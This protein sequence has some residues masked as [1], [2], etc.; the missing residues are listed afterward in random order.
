M[1]ALISPKGHLYEMADGGAAGQALR[2]FLTP[3]PPVVKAGVT[4]TDTLPPP[5]PGAGGASITGQTIAQGEI[6]SD[7]AYMGERAWKVK[8]TLSITLDISGGGM[9]IIG[10][11][12]G[13][14]GGAG[15]G[16]ASIQAEGTGDGIYYVSTKGVLLGGSDTMNLEMSISIGQSGMQIPISIKTQNTT[17]IV[18]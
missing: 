5:Q 15:G 1:S 13:G 4:W 12:G 3:L 10:G 17:A 11:G 18:R 16:G 2:Q 14:G 9:A 8:R 6:I 7:T